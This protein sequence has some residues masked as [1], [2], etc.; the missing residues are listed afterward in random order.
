[1]KS[2][3]KPHGQRDIIMDQHRVSIFGSS[4]VLGKEIN[5][6]KLTA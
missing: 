4:P 6:K 2:A 1:M 5:K 3:H